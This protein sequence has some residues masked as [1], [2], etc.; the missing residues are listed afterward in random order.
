M[1]EEQPIDFELLAGVEN[2]ECFGGRQ[3]M[4]REPLNHTRYLAGLPL[5]TPEQVA[6]RREQIIAEKPHNGL[7][8]MGRNK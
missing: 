3:S 6:L 8:L 4:A 2:A 7:W 1:T 5:T